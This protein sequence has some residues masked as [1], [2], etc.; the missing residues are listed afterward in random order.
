MD[1][2]E[3]LSEKMTVAGSIVYLT[4][5]AEPD[6][7][8]KERDENE[9]MLKVEDR[10][11]SDPGILPSPMAHASFFSKYI[12]MWWLNSLLIKGSK[13]PLVAE[14]LYAIL[15][16][17]QTETVTDALESEWEKEMSEAEQQGKDPS[18]LS[19]LRRT[20][21]VGYSLLGLVAL[22]RDILKI[23]GPIFLG[24]LVRYFVEDSPISTRD[25]YLYAIGLSLCS[26]TSSLFNAPFTFMSQVYGMRIRVACTGLVYRKSLKLSIAALH[27]TTTGNIVNLISSDTQ[28]FD[29][30]APNLHYLII[31]PVIAVIVLVVLWLQIGPSALAGMGLIL[32]LATMQFKM[33]N[34]LFSFRTKAIHWM[35]ERVKV[36]NEII[37][38][39][40]VI[41]MY[42]WEDSFSNWVRQ[43]RK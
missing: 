34:T 16:G 2:P 41:K 42:T 19:A 25:A 6:V 32:L 43:I 7:M 14:D 24:Q 33:G 21:G 20:F 37:A 10:R 38:G 27:G 9:P 5:D 31:G 35:D 30:T 1:D 39:M 26:L 17:E 28:K 11:K 13:Q 12:T 18:F 3:M 36:M 15:D 8:K 22:V 29:W 23:A 4:D 40:R